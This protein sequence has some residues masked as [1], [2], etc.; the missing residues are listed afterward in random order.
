MQTSTRLPSSPFRK[1]YIKS[2][3]QN[4]L[5]S[6]KFINFKSTFKNP[7]RS[8]EN[9]RLQCE[10][11]ARLRQKNSSVLVKRGKYDQF[12]DDKSIR[13]PSPN[14]FAL[15]KSFKTSDFY[16]K[17]KNSLSK[18]SKKSLPNIFSMDDS[19]DN[20]RSKSI[21]IRKIQPFQAK[22]EKS[23]L[24][25]IEEFNTK[26]KILDKSSKMHNFMQNMSYENPFYDTHTSCKKM[27]NELN[28]IRINN[29]SVQRK[30]QIEMG[31]L[32]SNLKDKYVRKKKLVPPTM[33]EITRFNTYYTKQK[34]LFPSSKNNSPI[35]YKNYDHLSNAIYSK[36]NISDS[37]E[38][39][40]RKMN[41][42]NPNREILIKR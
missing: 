2:L 12:K 6:K 13:S 5:K 14:N 4:Q 28:L 34:L 15:K 24:R 8:V 25:K 3:V 21:F 42:K 33:D 19:E 36:Y 27:S 7:K 35:K 38:A 29:H 16:L 22:I 31:E 9:R 1:E 11:L 20:S 30:K 23:T 39:N 26:Y 41:N 18:L 17:N 37:L 10:S 32:V 40:A